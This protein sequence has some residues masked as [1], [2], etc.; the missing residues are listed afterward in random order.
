MDT[1]NLL[2]RERPRC[3][4]KSSVE[5]VCH[6]KEEYDVIE[7]SQVELRDSESKGRFRRV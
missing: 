6:E 1:K 7:E 4:T 5:D 3:G 2:R